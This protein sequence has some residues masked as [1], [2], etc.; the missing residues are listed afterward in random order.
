MFLL[1]LR[2][3]EYWGKPLKCEGGETQEQ[4]R[5][6]WWFKG[7]FDDCKE[8]PLGKFIKSFIWMWKGF[9]CKWLDFNWLELRLGR[10]RNGVITAG[11]SCFGKRKL[12]AGLKLGRNVSIFRERKGENW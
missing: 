6:L 10:K 3:L 9:N 8:F 5:H 4:V 11:K 7:G 1:I 12:L 2:L